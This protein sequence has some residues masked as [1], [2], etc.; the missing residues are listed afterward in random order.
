MKKNFIYLL[1]VLLIASS[2]NAKEYRADEIEISYQKTQDGMRRIEYSHIDHSRK[3]YNEDGSLSHEIFY[4]NGKKHHKHY[5]KN[6][7]LHTESISVDGKEELRK[8]Y[9]KDGSLD[10]ETFYVNGK[11]HQKNYYYLDGMTLFRKVE[12]KTDYEVINKFYDKNGKLKFEA[13]TDKNAFDIFEYDK[14]GRKKQIPVKDIEEGLKLLM[15]LT[16]SMSK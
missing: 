11:Q 8:R 7:T 16:E 10:N 13:K 6:G 5:Y 4:V 2:V 3:E 9:R 1:F 12:K 14:N 15:E